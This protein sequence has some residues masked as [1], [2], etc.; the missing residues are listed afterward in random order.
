MSRSTLP[1]SK[2]ISLKI[3]LLAGEK[4]SSTPR[5]IL[6]DSPAEPVKT[7]NKPYDQV[8]LNQTA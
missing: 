3:D 1:Q 5:K 6:V 7:S 4:S 2:Y 8:I